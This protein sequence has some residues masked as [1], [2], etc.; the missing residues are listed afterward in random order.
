M[1]LPAAPAHASP[2]AGTPFITWNLRGATTEGQSVWPTYIPTLVRENPDTQVIMIQEAGP[3]A[4]D[5]AT[6]IDN[7]PG[8]ADARVTSWTYTVQG[9]GVWYLYFIW[10]TD[11]TLN[12]RAGGRVNTIVMSRTKAQELLVVDNNFIGPAR[13]AIGI[14]LDNDYY[15]SYHALSGGG[16]DAVSTLT[17][18]GQAVADREDRAQVPPGTYNWTVGAD[19]NADPVRLRTRPGYENIAPGRQLEPLVT[20]QGTHRNRNFELDGELDYAVTTSPTFPQLGARLLNGHLASDHEPVGVR[21]GPSTSSHNSGTGLDEAADGVRDVAAQLKTLTFGD[22]I[23]AGVGSSNGSGY[24]CDLQND[25]GIMGDT[26]QFVGSLTAGSGCSQLATEGH[27]GWTI[28]QLAGIEHC[29][30]K[31]LQPNLVLLDIGTND[32]NLGGAPGPAVT[33]L[34]NLVN[35]IMSD[36]PNATVV[37]SSLIPTPNPTVAANMRA[38]NAEASDWVRQQQIAGR[39]MVW[40]DQRS[41]QLSDLADGL[42]PNDTGYDKMAAN[43][44]SAIRTGVDQSMLQPAA[45][46]DSTACGQ[47]LWI[48]KGKIALG[49]GSGSDQPGARPLPAGAHVQFAD[50][51]GDG[52]ADYLQINGDSSV[53]AWLNTG[54]GPSGGIIWQSLGRVALGVG[55][56][57]SQVQFARIAGSGRADYLVVDPTNGAVTMWR[58]DGTNAAGLYLWSPQGLTAIGVPPPAGGRVTFGDI[59]GDGKDDY[60]VVDSGGGV[61]EWQ[62]QGP[63]S[64]GGWQWYSLGP[65]AYSG[66]AANSGE[67]RYA[68]LDGDGKADYLLVNSGSGSVQAWLTTGEGPGGLSFIGVVATGVGDIGAN[69]Q[70]AQVYG[71]GRADYLDVNPTDGTVKAWKNIGPTPDGPGSGHFWLWHPEGSIVDG[72]AARVQFADLNGDGR[73]DYLKVNADGSVQAWRN[74]GI[75]SSDLPIW[76]G[77]TTVALGVGDPGINIQFAPVF[78]TGRADYLDVNQTTGAVTAW[79][80][81][82]VNALGVINWIPRGQ[83]ALGTPAGGT[84]VHFADVRGNGRADYL[85]FDPITGAIN[86]YVNVGFNSIG[87]FVWT[88]N[89]TIATGVGNPGNQIRLAPIYGTGRADY[90]A[91]NPDSSVRAWK[92]AGPLGTVGDGGWLWFPQGTIA[93]GVGVQGNLVQFADIWGTGRADYLVVNPADG[94]VD[95]WHNAGLY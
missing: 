83:I 87:Y 3:E 70:F 34:K 77:P 52:K 81:G 75:S 95:A 30:I 88:P 47:P 94:S 73:A 36:D 79:E 55:V 1:A 22:S 69:I 85:T 41:V 50:L 10:S 65:I 74:A 17:R 91:V 43:W 59:N 56:P 80:N 5:S 26:Y 92:N 19:F 58:N 53:D 23:T 39:R 63:I 7:P 33:A 57:G 6:Q 44:N 72:V 78:G 48:P 62:N 61:L 29:T 42:H 46:P 71:T 40:A 84:Q 64:G 49:F 89:G 90:L 66:A 11:P 12:G 16:G 13:P 2:P 9:G 76:V 25:L 45:A 35:N 37:V 4:P 18:I 68:D 60:L 38:F 86:D 27:G 54:W 15:F 82:G 32:I 93:A 14:R 51:N 67:V 28:S 21:P 8:N 20:G 31:G 24:R